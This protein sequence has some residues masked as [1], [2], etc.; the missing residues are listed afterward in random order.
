MQDVAKNLELEA[1]GAQ[2]LVIWTD[3]DREGE[4]IGFEIVQVCRRAN[5]R[6]EVLRGRFSVVQAREIHQAMRNLV[7]L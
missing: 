3:C 2:T 1:R 6:I 4:N 7:P 5:P